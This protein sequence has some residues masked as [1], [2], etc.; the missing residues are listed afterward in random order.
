MLHL[1]IDRSDIRVR[2]I[3]H[4][5]TPV[6]APAGAV[7]MQVD[8]FALTSNN[9]SYALAGDALDYWGFFPASAGWGR[10]PVMGFATV[11]SSALHEIPEGSRYFGFFPAGSHHIVEARP[12]QGGFVDA[13]PHREGHA[14]A[15]RSFDRVGAVNDDERYV[16]LLRGLFVT[17]YLCADFLDDNDSF[18]AEQ[19][20][21]TS[22][23]SKTSLALAHELRRLGRWRVV[24]MTSPP[25]VGFVTG[26]AFY[27]DV[28]SY[29]RI[30]TLDAACPSVVVDMAGDTALLGR[31][32]DH[33]GTSLAYSCRI[34][35]THWEKS[36]GAGPST[37]PAPAFFFAP[38]QLAKRVEHMGRG[39]F[40]LA[41]TQALSVFLADAPRWL[42]VTHSHGAPAMAEV[43]D[44]LVAGRV[45]PHVGHIVSVAD[46]S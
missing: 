37:G 26:T 3:A 29:D 12:T 21:V 41:L 10:L 38:T 1:E 27:D 22:A 45:A 30:G 6:R 23:S 35:A 8:H 32:H 25:N 18:G 31:L 36:S 4:D 28:V 43:Y 2:R 7:T 9:V 46:P 40:H 14:M 39:P 42:T 44:D 19:V 15:Y 17:S 34:G 33:F 13:S 24:A 11:V 16:A 20:V 5:L